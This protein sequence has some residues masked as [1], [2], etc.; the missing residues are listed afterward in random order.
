MR[1]LYTLCGFIIVGIDFRGFFNFSQKLVH[2]KY[3]NSCSSAKISQSVLKIIRQTSTAK[4]NVLFKKNNKIINKN[5]N[6]IAKFSKC[7]IVSIGQF[8]KF[9]TREKSGFKKFAKSEI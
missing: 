2:A 6:K 7:E 9:N 4:I 3:L 1:D 8:A 5:N